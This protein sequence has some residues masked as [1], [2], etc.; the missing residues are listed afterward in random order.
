LQQIWF[1]A[2]VGW[3]AKLHGVPRVIEQVNTAARLLLA[4]MEAERRRR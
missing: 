2:L 4:G 1:A 3:T